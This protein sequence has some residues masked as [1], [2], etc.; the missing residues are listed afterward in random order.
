MHK[1]EKKVTYF[2]LPLLIDLTGR[3]LNV[4]YALLGC[5][6]KP[7]IKRTFSENPQ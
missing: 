5:T 6:I 3:L 7:E 2:F 1:K 4:S